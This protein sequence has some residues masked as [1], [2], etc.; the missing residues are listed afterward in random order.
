LILRFLPKIRKG[1]CVRFAKEEG[2]SARIFCPKK[3]FILLALLMVLVASLT[4]FCI[5]VYV[6]HKNWYIKFE[7]KDF[8]RGDRSNSEA[9]DLSA[10]RK[11]EKM[12]CP[13]G[14]KRITFF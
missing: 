6:R 8:D 1:F 4:F 9:C 13:G 2:T 7:L 5:V 3:V 10:E 14:G 12:L 11:S